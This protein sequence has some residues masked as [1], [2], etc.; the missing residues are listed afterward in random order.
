MIDKRDIIEGIKSGE[1]I[2]EDDYMEYCLDNDFEL[3]YAVAESIHTP[4]D[5]LKVSA[6]YQ[7]KAI[8]IAVCKNKNV[9]YETLKKLS[10]S[11][12]IDVYRMAQQYLQI[13]GKME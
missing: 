12:D 4:S 13:R 6:L 3:A 8:Q 5:I 9:S 10:E 2:T 1:N 11:K 7:N